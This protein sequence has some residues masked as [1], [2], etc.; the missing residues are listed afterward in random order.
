MRDPKRI[1]VVLDALARYWT[2]NPDLRLGQI[3]VNMTIATGREDPF[4]IDDE[5]ILDELLRR[6]DREEG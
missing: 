3:V 2:A 5:N 1:P 6:L 4:F